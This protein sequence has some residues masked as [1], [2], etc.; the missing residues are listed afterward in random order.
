M[1]IGLMG[2]TFNPPHMGHINA[3]RAAMDELS[4]DRLIF[5]PTGTPPHKEM[6]EMS[7]TTKQRLEMTYLAAKTLGAEVS[8]IEIR[9]EGKSFTVYTLRELHSKYPDDELW[10]IM[11]TDMFL[12]LETW[13]CFEE[14]FSLASVAAVAREDDD[15]KRL[16][17]HSEQL[18]RKYGAKTRVLE[19]A[20]L[21][22]SSTELRPGNNRKELRDFLP[23]EVYDYIIRKN[24]YGISGCDKI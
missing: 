1:R 12:S 19:A 9:R 3:A 16:L 4:L 5:I 14:I 23:P 15:K 6:A 10:L 11:G 13:F 22:V 2:G 21:T 24:L 17:A 8:D 7:A 20:A 18:K